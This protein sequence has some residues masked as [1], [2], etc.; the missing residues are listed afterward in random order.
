MMPQNSPNGNPYADTVK[1]RVADVQAQ[2]PEPRPDGP[3]SEAWSLMLA[4]RYDE[5]AKLLPPPKTP[6][7]V[8]DRADTPHAIL[9]ALAR[10][11]KKDCP[12]D[13]IPTESDLCAFLE[14]PE[15]L[16]VLAPL[17]ESDAAGFA[18]V[19]H[20]PA[21]DQLTVLA[22]GLAEDEDGRLTPPLLGIETA[23]ARW[24]ALE[25]RPEHPLLPLVKAWQARPTPVEPNTRPDRTL[26]A[27]IAMIDPGDRR[28]GGLFTPAMHSLDGQPPLPGFGEYMPKSTP[29]LYLQLYDLGV[30]KV[31]GERGG[32]AA[33]LALR[34]WVEAILS[35]G[36]S[37]RLRNHPVAMDISLR[38]LLAKLYPNRRP[39][40][41]EY[42][43]RLMAAVEALDSEQA[44]IPWED[45]VTGRGG[46]RRVVSMG[47]IPRGAGALDD[48]VTLI[49]HMP[50]GAHEGP[51]V[52]PNLPQWGV[53]SAA[54]Y[55]A[56]IGLAF[57]WWHPGVTRLPV[58]RGKRRHWYQSDNPKH[59]DK[60]T[61]A[62]AVALCFPT[63]A[64]AQRRNL[65]PE[66]WR[67]LSKLVV[68]GEARKE[69]GRLLPP[70]GGYGCEE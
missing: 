25:P 6:G 34:L 43:P 44:R 24:L 1:Q 70:A 23:H 16:A 22:G 9:E 37:D 62:E 33:P 30:G 4:G 65:I 68:E 69:E 15:T 52:S 53:K 67:V 47:D 14:L 32:H 59:Y 54:A 31:A 12:P 11:L 64:R 55:R 58:G 28:A 39:S 5:A 45:P 29:A 17:I 40:P 35:V 60:L 63:S 8:Q 56:L 50:P 51:I 2:Q 10:E 49:V 41:A 27:R 26:P 42:W 48:L 18:V 21:P 3:S 61:D 13:Q 38:D 66:A 19:S 20:H 46:L 57:R 7:D 36:L